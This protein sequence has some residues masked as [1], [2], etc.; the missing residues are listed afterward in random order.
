MGES[1]MNLEAESFS[2]DAIFSL[3]HVFYSENYCQQ[4]IKQSQLTPVRGGKAEQRNGITKINLL[5]DLSVN[6]PD[7]KK[8]HPPKFVCHH[9]RNSDG[10]YN[11]TL[12]SCHGDTSDAGLKMEDNK[13]LNVSREKNCGREN[14]GE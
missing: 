7:G 13:T 9:H 8:P 2:Y 6:Q 4:I 12:Y 3:Q 1:R 10:I 11:N 5:V 14:N